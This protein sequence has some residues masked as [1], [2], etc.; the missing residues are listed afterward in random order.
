MTTLSFSGHFLS[1][2]LVSWYLHSKSLVDVTTNH[3]RAE[4][5]S[6]QVLSPGVAS[7]PTP[8]T[9][10]P[11]S[12][13]YCQRTDIHSFTNLVPQCLATVLIQHL[14]VN[15]VWLSI[16]FS[17]CALLH[18]SG[19]SRPKRVCC[20]RCKYFQGTTNWL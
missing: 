14:F 13:P 10:S 19:I 6:S 8:S 17:P 7:Q 4:V 5:A 1:W 18:M 20:K 3:H 16:I 11:F 12:R 15:R 2:T 9:L